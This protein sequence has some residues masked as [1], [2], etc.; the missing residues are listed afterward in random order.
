MNIN[1]LNTRKH[2]IDTR[3]KR[4][5]Y[6]TNTN[7]QINLPHTVECPDN[8]VIYVDE[9]VLLNTITPIQSNVN[10]T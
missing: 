4:D 3:F 10:D 1:N 5:K 8:C 2:Y 7:F 6:G 9:L